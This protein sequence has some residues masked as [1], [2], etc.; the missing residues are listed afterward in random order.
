MFFIVYLVSIL[1]SCVGMTAWL[2]LG[3][4]DNYVPLYLLWPLTGHGLNAVFN[5]VIWSSTGDSNHDWR[6]QS[7]LVATLWG[8]L[9]VV[10]TTLAV[11]CSTANRTVP[12]YGALIEASLI[13]IV[14]LFGLVGPS[15][16]FL[17]FAW[18]CLGQCILWVQLAAD[19][20]YLSASAY[21][22][23]LSTRRRNRWINI[24]IA[25]IEGP[26]VVL[27]NFN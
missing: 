7:L 6:M 13:A 1:L 8:P 27:H 17:P 18:V 23:L 11:L 24:A 9:A 16:W 10:P 4:S 12:L 14:V 21:L 5:Y 20:D 19:P 15:V 3:G 25:A 2:T 26:L 22:E